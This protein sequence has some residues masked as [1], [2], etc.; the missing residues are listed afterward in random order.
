VKVLFSGPSLTDELRAGFPA[1]D[2]R[3]PAAR[4]D[5]TRAV[6]EGATAIGIVDGLFGS[7]PAVWHKE[8][9][10]A[11]AA[12]VRVAGGGSM[13][14]LRAA[15]CAA[16]GMVPIG[17]VARKFATG[18]EPD[19]AYVAQIHAPAELGWTALSEA[20]ANVDAT[21]AVLRR[22]GAVSA[23]EHAALTAASRA[24]YYADRTLDRLP[25]AAG[26]EEPRAADLKRRLRE[27]RVDRKR[28]DAIKVA[29]WLDR[30]PDERGGPPA[31]W[32]FQET[33]QWLAFLAEEGAS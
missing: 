33:S 29:R 13:G 5:V 24:M 30:Q 22:R 21:L 32:I 8:I 14:A 9:L 10:F 4:G 19:D 20:E 18:A 2:H 16:F 7:V 6:A 3:G 31:G 25:A 27:G 15:E 1:L 12:G 11:L 28:A 17:V 26:Y 23:A